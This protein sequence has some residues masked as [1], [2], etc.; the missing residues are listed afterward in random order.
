M[1]VCVLSIIFLYWFQ[2]LLN[3][4]G[5]SQVQ[6]YSDVII[7]RI[8]HGRVILQYSLGLRKDPIEVPF[9]TLVWVQ[10]SMDRKPF[11][12]RDGP[13]VPE[14]SEIKD[15][16]N[17]NPILTHGWENRFGLESDIKSDIF[18]YRMRD[19]A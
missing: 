2:A 15:L 4:L 12:T 19:K 1:N 3:I 10:R 5:Q 6:F 9:G 7:F 13:Q 18:I 8:R 17:Q 16:E 11:S 14:S